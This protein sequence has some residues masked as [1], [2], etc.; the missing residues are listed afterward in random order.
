MSV[1]TFG[2]YVAFSHSVD[3]R[4]DGLGRY[5]EVFLKSALR[6]KDVRFVVACPSWAR[7]PILEIC[8]AEDGDAEVDFVG[9]SEV[10]AWL[11]LTQTP[12]S[13]QFRKKGRR[14]GRRIAK[15]GRKGLGLIRW[16]IKGTSDIR[17]RPLLLLAMVG[18]VLLGL[19]V[20]PFVLLLR[21]VSSLMG[22][23]FPLTLGKARI[24]QQAKSV[25]RASWMNALRTSAV[26]VITKSM[27]KREI[28]LLQK[29][30]AAR[31]DVLAWY[32]PMA[33]WPSFNDIRAP[34]LLC[35]PDVLM[36][37][38]PVSSAVLGPK[39]EKSFDDVTT[40]IQGATDIVTYSDHVKWA[41]LVDQ[42][43]ISPRSIHCIR[44]A[45]FDLAPLITVVGSADAE[46]LSRRYCE[47]ILL[48]AVHRAQNEAFVSSTATSQFRFLFYASQVRPSKNLVTLLRAYKHLLRERFIG[49]KLVL[50]CHLSPASDVAKFIEE[51][52]LGADVLLL[53]R[54]SE[55]ELAACYKLADLT[56][57]PSL[58]EGG[59]PFTFTE[60][61]SVGT[62]VVMSDIEATREVL[63]DP[64][65]RELTLFDP[66]DWKA[67]ADKIEWALANRETLLT[68]QRLFYE[69]HLASRT[70]DDVVDDHIALLD[71]LV[72]RTHEAVG[73]DRP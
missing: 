31:K 45:A 53:H 51:H 13:D 29:A 26:S 40:V 1:K 19:L 11:R 58:F 43:G 68:A 46:L 54:L 47:V 60:A 66:Y 65:L 7:R 32:A 69:G 37:D 16:C 50:T 55:R 9:P 73:S 56:V 57:N 64:A 33:F 44:H 10:P 52:E 35:L 63:T 70:W 4:I 14:I 18:I 41:T 62:P 23:T 39:L 42:F 2:I 5:L 15:I 59:M 48:G 61:L 6:R 67:M 24:T 27:Q 8:S 30:V 25:R 34:R 3:L 22:V 28:A 21:G 12:A 72:E 49:L 17:S 71:E 36:V 20:L 38:F